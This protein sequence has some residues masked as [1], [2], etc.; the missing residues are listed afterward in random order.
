MRIGND[1]TIAIFISVS[2]FVTWATIS[3]D[4]LVWFF[5]ILLTGFTAIVGRSVKLPGS[6][7]SDNPV[8]KAER[9]TNLTVEKLQSETSSGRSEAVEVRESVAV[10]TTG[11]EEVTGSISGARGEVDQAIGQ[12]DDAIA[13]L[14]GRAPGKKPTTPDSLG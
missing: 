9:A 3:P 14:E 1:F 13:I 12:L 11:V 6:G 4:S 2:V 5:G 8:A 10:I 7:S